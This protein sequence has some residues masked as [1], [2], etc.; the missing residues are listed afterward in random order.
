MIGAASPFIYIEPEKIKA[1]I[2]KIFK[3]KGEEIINMNLNAFQMGRDHTLA[4]L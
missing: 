2:I 1:G 3:R 4:N